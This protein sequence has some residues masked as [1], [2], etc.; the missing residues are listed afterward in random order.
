MARNIEFIPEEKVS[1]AMHV[2]WNK[3]YTAASLS[4]LTA[5]MKINKSSLYNSFGNKH[6]LFKECLKAYGKLVQQDYASA[7]QKGS[8]ALE[9][10]DNIINKIVEISTERANSCLGVK[11][12]F[13]L[14]SKDK[15]INAVI[16][17]GNDKTI[18]LITSLIKE[19]QINGKIGSNRDAETMAHF[20]F[21]SFSGLRQSY[22]IYGNTKLVKKMGN[23][24]KAFL[25]M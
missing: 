10:L 8:N 14:A 25:R 15:E 17:S 7:I 4:E 20:V 13:E 18:G 2:F 22:I 9:K 3:G 12:S 5:A 6:T 19:A 1:E 21:N 16:K 11:T 24:L 23:E